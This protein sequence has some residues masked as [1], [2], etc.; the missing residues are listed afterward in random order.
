MEEPQGKTGPINLVVQVSEYDLNAGIAQAI[1]HCVV[2]Q[3]QRSLPTMVAAAVDEAIQAS[4]LQ[5]IEIGVNEDMDL[6]DYSGA[7]KERTS[8]KKKVGEVVHGITEKG[9]DYVVVKSQY[10]S[11]N[12]TVKTFIDEAI[13]ALITKDLE[14]LRAQV[15]AEFKGRAAVELIQSVAREIV[16]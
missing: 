10:S 14:A 1:R 12:K 8:M 16:K 6:F 13:K 3:V 5:A 9:L 11:D 15:K 7:V 4:I 2:E